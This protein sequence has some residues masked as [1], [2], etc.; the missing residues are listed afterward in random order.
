[1]K[2][3]NSDAQRINLTFVVHSFVANLA[4]CISAKYYLNWFSFH[5]VI[6]KVI[7]VNFFETQCIMAYMFMT[8]RDAAMLGLY[9]CDRGS[10]MTALLHNI[11]VIS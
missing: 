9:Y 5:T 6:M 10:W 7:G 8:S 1:L 2:L 4:N 3:K 11:V